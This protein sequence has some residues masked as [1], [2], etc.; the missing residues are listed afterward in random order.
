MQTIGRNRRKILVNDSNIVIIQ[1]PTQWASVLICKSAQQ[2]LY[3]YVCYWL[4]VTRKSDKGFAFRFFSSAEN[5]H[6]ATVHPAKNIPQQPNLFFPFLH[7]TNGLTSK[8]ELQNKRDQKYPILKFSSCIMNDQ[9]Y[10]PLNE[11]QNH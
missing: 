8:Y 2:G 9:M 10:E 4:P 7:S 1:V 6:F 5:C 3:D 11:N